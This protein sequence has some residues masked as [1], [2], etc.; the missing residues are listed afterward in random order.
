MLVGKLGT[1][2]KFGRPGGGWLNCVCGLGGMKAGGGGG[3]GPLFSMLADELKARGG[4][5]ELR[6]EDL[7]SR[8]LRC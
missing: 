2:G 5:Y 8:P 1:P 7:V 3:G 4:E 6:D